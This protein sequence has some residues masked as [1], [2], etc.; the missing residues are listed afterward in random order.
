[1]V[2]VVVIDKR[3]KYKMLKID[4]E[5]LIIMEKMEHSYQIGL[6]RKKL[7]K[8]LPLL[9]S[10]LF[11]TMLI[12]CCVSVTADDQSMAEQYAPVF[13]FEAM[14]TCFPVTA[15]YHID[16][17]RLYQ[18]PNQLIEEN[19]T[20]S[21]IG[22]FTGETY[23]DY[24]LDNQK[25]S[26]QTDAIISDY[27]NKMNQL[28][29]TVYYRVYPFSGGHVVQYW[30]FYAFNKGELNQHE[31]DWEMVQIY[32]TSGS[33]SAMMFSQHESGQKATMEQVEKTNGQPNVYVARGS[34]ANY[35]RSYSGKLGVANDI[36][37]SNGKVLSSSD[38]QLVPLSSQTWLPFSGRW[39][40]MNSVEDTFLGKSG[41]YGP[42]YRQEGNMW[43][44]PDVW[45]MALPAADNTILLLELFLYHFLTI[46]IVVTLVTIA[47]L[48]IRLWKQHKKT[49]LGPRFLSCLYIDGLN[50][51]SIGNLLFIGGI[52]IALIAVFSPW[53]VISAEISTPEFSTQGF[54]D[55]FVIDGMNG[56]Q[57]SYPGSNGPIPMGTLVLPF[58]VFILI[59]IAFTIF[60]TIGV[61]ESTVLG[62]KYLWRGVRL[63]I[64]FILLIIGV[65]LIG[66]MVA[67][68]GYMGLEQTSASSIFSSLSSSPF[69]GSDSV[70]LMESGVI[71]TVNMQWGFALGGYLFVVAGILLII[72]GFCEKKAQTTFFT[73]AS[74]KEPF[75]QKAPSE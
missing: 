74:K 50:L 37:G 66:N 4:D 45:G 11:F 31:G 21:G 62:K 30:M 15:Q 51:K 61:S 2:E 23:N 53:Y 43:N 29:Y 58:G 36:V 48:F 69:G 27:Q 5:S 67:N 14:E 40:E 12:N 72:G 71:G 7:I 49:G 63:L 65:V 68:M 34:H 19:P 10:L 16:T 6:V 1:M 46:F 35:L 42:M 47:F 18:Y 44:Q 28:G 57:I 54:L 60:K 70:T 55:F 33:P 64:P 26:I 32:I 73:S 52:I 41:P 56:V 9:V 75:I 20:S 24:Y 17:S 39:G 25:G 3:N 22:A 8:R 59:G 38:Y 13:Y